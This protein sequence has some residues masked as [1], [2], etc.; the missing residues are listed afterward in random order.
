MKYFYSRT[1]FKFLNTLLSSNFIDTISLEYNNFLKNMPES[2]HKKLKAIKESDIL[3]YFLVF[4]KYNFGKVT[5][6]FFNLFDIHCSDFNKN[7]GP[8]GNLTPNRGILGDQ[9]DLLIK[10]I[11][12]I[13]DPSPLL[14]SFDKSLEIINSLPFEPSVC[15]FLHFLPGAVIH[16]HKHDP[17]HSVI[18][19]LLED[20]L[21]GKLWVEVG[22]EFQTLNKRG[23]FIMF[24]QFNYHQAKLIGD[25]ECKLF[26][27][28]INKGVYENY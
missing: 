26:S 12:D 14:N 13:K 24:D 9:K 4:I 6:P 23:D 11:N 2:Q 22:D 20:I 19:L 16:K 10:N 28:G 8:D 18:H 27:F 3:R 21:D 5:T 7:D 17:N 25:K 15:G 1:D